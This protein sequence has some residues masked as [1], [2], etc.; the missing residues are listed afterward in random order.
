M[1][2]IGNQ[3]NGDRSPQGSWTPQYQGSQSPW[4]TN[5]ENIQFEADNVYDKV[6]QSVRPVMEQLHSPSEQNQQ[7]H[8]VLK[9]M[10]YTMEHLLDVMTE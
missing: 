5:V 3:S 1:R 8:K 2:K 10:R 7:S 4:R 9:V 6:A